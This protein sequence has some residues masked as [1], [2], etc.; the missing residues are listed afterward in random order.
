VKRA[1][2]A[3]PPSGRADR[4]TSREVGVA[5]SRARKASSAPV[6]LADVARFAG[7]ST[8]S[9]SRAINAPELVSAGLRERIIHAAE[10]LNWVP[11]GAAK[12]LASQHSRTIGAIIPT[13]GHQNFATLIEALQQELAK[14]NY[15]LVLGCV[16]SSAYD[17]RVQLGRKMIERGV[18]CLVLVGEAQPPQLL[19]LLRI[20]RIPS[21]ITYTSG[22]I[23][24]STCI[25]FDNYAAAA[26]IA[27]H[28]IDLGHRTFGMIAP[29]QEGNDRIQQRIAGVKDAL[30]HAGLAIRPQH[31]A[32]V[33]SSRRIESGR[34]A[35]R[36]VLA[37]PDDRPTALVCT[38]DYIAM[39]AMIEAAA[40]RIAVPGDVSITGFDDID[41]SAHLVPPL[42]TVRVPAR[43]MGDEI[44]RY[45]IRHLDTGAA[46]VPP[47]LQ[48]ELI[49]RGSTAPPRQR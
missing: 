31:F 47:P 18:D 10:V 30:A 40:T 3:K 46:P 23:A 16:E 17:L 15:A 24:G 35:L 14:A 27:R 1:G 8:A 42:T 29:S 9:V 33:D 20:Q 34:A 28:L 48:A 25:G 12:A 49:V 11:N 21:V 41:L 2:R 6:R 44:A 37:G 38:N 5:R 7:V 4:K 13:L 36:H 22:K 32:E 43:Q 45:V 39:G 26:R 19:E